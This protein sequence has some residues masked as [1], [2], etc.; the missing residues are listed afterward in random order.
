MQRTFFANSTLVDGVNAPQPGKTI[1]VQ[2][3]RIAAVCEAGEAPSPESADRAF[4][5]AG[6]AVMPG[7][8][9]CHLHAAMDDIMSYM[10]LDL[11]YPANY[12]TLIAARNVERML[13]L[14]FTSA[15]GAGSPANIDITLKHAI[16]SSLINGPRLTACGR[17]LCTTGES[18]DF[19]PT[20]WKTGFLG[21]GHACDG[22][23]EF[24]KAIRTE[25][26]DGV[27]IVK[28]HVTGGHGSN[29]P[30][31]IVPITQDE[32]LAAVDAAHERG[33]KIRAHSANKEGILACVKA[34]VDLVDHVDFLDDECIEAF[35]KHDVTITPG[36]HVTRAFIDAVL[37]GQRAA[38]QGAPIPVS[39]LESP[40]HSRIA[41]TL[42]EA[43]MAMDHYREFLPK[44]LQA[45]VNIVNGDDTG[46]AICPHGTYANELVTYVKEVGIPARDAI[47][48]ATRNAA[49]F[50]GKTDL[51]VIAEGKLADLIV[52]KGNPVDDITVLRHPEKIQVVMKDG[53]LVECKLPA[54]DGWEGMTRDRP[55]EMLNLS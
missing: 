31:D 27:D 12:L 30:I 18:L 22:P 24:R 25:I 9:Q 39:P 44:A 1:I 49:R 6:S 19:H 28:I 38:E 46:G 13:R 35:V 26:K 54:G 15:I 55:L 14:G 2:G 37:A 50:L 47:S 10:E 48:W 41:S 53:E 5:L 52:V 36:V 23:D 43:Q 45:G 29:Y 51:G 34:G 33:R 17:H 42:E 32:L 3:N 11:K 40:F 7:M 21:F 20:F 8:F 16:N 4:D